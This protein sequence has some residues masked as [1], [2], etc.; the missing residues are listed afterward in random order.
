MRQQT[1]A[2]CYERLLEDVDCL[3][4]KVLGEVDTLRLT[5]GYE[6][7]HGVLAPVVVLK[8]MKKLKELLARGKEPQKRKKGEKDR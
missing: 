8:H 5:Q 4:Y 7:K 3:K 1:L 2:R 6:E